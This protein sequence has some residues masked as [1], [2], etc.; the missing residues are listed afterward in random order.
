MSELIKVKK[1]VGPTINGKKPLL[2]LNNKQKD[3]LFNDIAKEWKKLIDLTFL[4]E[5]GILLNGGVRK[6]KPLSEDYARYKDLNS[7]SDNILEFSVPTLA[8]RYKKSITIKPK[9][10]QIYITYPNLIHGKKKGQGVT[11]EVHQTGI[12]EIGLPA[13]RIII[14][15]FKEVVRV[16][17]KKHLKDFIN[18][19]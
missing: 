17:L 15:S 4:I 12:P 16:Q 1:I 3:K 14:S 5:G 11:A 8:S 18:N 13:R 19:K 7:S 6:W 10:N 2:G 9:E